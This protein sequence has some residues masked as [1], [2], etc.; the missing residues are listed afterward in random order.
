[1][2]EIP[3]ISAGVAELN[4]LAHHGGRLASGGASLD[5]D[6]RI[7]ARDVRFSEVEGTLQGLEYPVSRESAASQLADVKLILADGETNLG[8]LIG[9]AGDDEFESPDD[10]L[11]G[12]HN[13][14]PRSAVG[15]PYQSDGDS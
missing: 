10:L 12:L 7:M 11:A 9:S 8:E 5:E 2:S 4:S 1:M 6:S 13:T 3:R 15:E 14:L